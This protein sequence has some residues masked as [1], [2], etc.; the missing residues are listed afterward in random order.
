MTYCVRPRLY[1]ALDISGA[2]E[3]VAGI[4]HAGSILVVNLEAGPPILA[5]PE[6][7]TVA[8]WRD[9]APLLVEY[10]PSRLLAAS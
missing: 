8:E 3:H 7:G 6:V 10:L 4:R 5:V 2:S 9:E 1:I